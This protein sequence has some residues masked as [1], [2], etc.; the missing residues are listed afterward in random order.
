MKN[1]API[2]STIQ[3]VTK[4]LRG[5]KLNFLL[6]IECDDDTGVEVISNIND[7]TKYLCYL[8]TA[9]N[10]GDEQFFTLN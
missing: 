9:T 3:E 4:M 7:H 1:Q 2:K 6:A 5:T 10:I 8:L